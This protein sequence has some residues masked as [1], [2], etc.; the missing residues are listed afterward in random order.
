MVTV[1]ASNAGS[2][3]DPLITLSYLRGTYTESLRADVSTALGNAADKAM[4]RLDEIYR[5]YIGY[6]FAPKFTHI[7]LASGDS[8]RLTTGGSF[9]LLSGTA[10]LTISSGNVINVSTGNEVTSAVQLALNQR[11]FCAEN[12]TV[13]I[14]ASAAATGQVD[15]FY[16]T[17]GTA[18]PVPQ[19]PFT[20][21]RATDWFY[22]AVDFVYKNNLFQGTSANAF[23]P[24]VSMTRGMFVTVLHRLDGLPSAGA[25]GGFSD[26]SDRTLYY[27]N[28]V[29]WANEN[30]IVEGYADGTF[31]PDASVTREQMAT[32]MHRYAIYKGRDM[33]ASETAY[34][35]FPDRNSVS[36]YAVSPLQWAVSWG[37]ITGSDGRLLPQSTA[38][39]AQVAQIIFN[40]CEKIGR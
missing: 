16:L 22:S 36:D 24:G 19:L 1:S 3:G 39:R 32:I 14:T 18:T 23:S 31:R 17:D 37:V 27:Y 30:K 9:I 4:S 33:T 10:T 38:T 29:T 5:N 34:N 28:A 6:N 8:V 11:Y 21:V 15:G 40:Y 35:A 12:T 20:D 25:G 2:T 26:V 7:S 13:L